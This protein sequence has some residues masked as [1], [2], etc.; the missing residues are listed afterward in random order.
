MSLKDLKEF[1]D[2]IDTKLDKIDD[3]LSSID[4]T[5]VKQNAELEHHIYRT[6]I[7]EQKLELLRIEFKPVK[8]HVDRVNFVF[9]IIGI[10]S[11]GLGLIIGTGKILVEL[12]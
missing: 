3:R 7:A 8:R 5:L 2:K 1:G 11:T 4:V 10:A 9:R 6:E 12:F